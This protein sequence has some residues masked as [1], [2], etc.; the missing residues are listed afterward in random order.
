MCT[1]RIAVSQVNTTI[2][3]GYPANNTTTITATP[4]IGQSVELQCARTSVG[5][6]WYTAGSQVKPTSNEISTIS[7]NTRIL[8]FSSFAPSHAG[9]YTCLVSSP[10]D[11]Q[12]KT[13]YPVV[14][15]E[16]AAINQTKH[17]FIKYVIII[18]FLQ[19]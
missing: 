10:G 6:Q 3:V 8:A 11:T 14:L 2:R 5:K 9:T 18:I 16:F 13:T 7:G 17:N 12:T 19:L 15:G 4:T 1:V